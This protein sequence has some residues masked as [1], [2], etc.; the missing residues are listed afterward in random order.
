MADPT[1]AGL[2]GMR[3][4]F[5]LMEFAVVWRVV[6]SVGLAVRVREAFDQTEVVMSEAVGKPVAVAQR[7]AMGLQ[8]VN[9]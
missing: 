2:A 6:R 8:G 3:S 4:V 9:Q 5:A 7:I 1:A